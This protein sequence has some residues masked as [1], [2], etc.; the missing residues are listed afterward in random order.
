MKNRSFGFTLIELLIAVSIVGLLAA[1]AV[2][3]YQKNVQR[4][5][6]ADA[7]AALNQAAAAEE[8][9]Y[10]SN[11]KYGD[12]TAIGITTTSTEGYYTIGAAIGGTD[13]SFTITA[14]ARGIQ[15]GDTDCA[16]L[17]L[18]NT[19]SRT[20]SPDTNGCWHR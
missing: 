9:Y 14:T 13:Q 15:A 18:S 7:I 10:F 8:K 20:P 4:S 19:G 12:N 11:N 6:R 1:L 17:T 5:R 2:P 3:A 16:Q